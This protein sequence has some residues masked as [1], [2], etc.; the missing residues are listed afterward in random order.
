MI[1]VFPLW[2]CENFFWMQM[3]EQKKGRAAAEKNKQGKNDEGKKKSRS[4]FFFIL[5]CDDSTLDSVCTFT[6]LL[7][8]LIPWSISSNHFFSRV[9][10]D[11]KSGK[12]YANFLNWRQK[13]NILFMPYPTFLSTLA[14]DPGPL[15][16]ALLFYL[17]RLEK[18]EKCDK[19]RWCESIKLAVRRDTN[20]E[21][22][23]FFLPIFS[24]HP[25]QPPPSIAWSD[26]SACIDM[27]KMVSSYLN[28]N[29]KFEKLKQQQKMVGE[30][31]NVKKWRFFHFLSVF[32]PRISSPPATRQLKSHG[33]SNTRRKKKSSE[34]WKTM[35]RNIEWKVPC[36]D[37][38]TC[39]LWLFRSF[40]SH[41]SMAIF[42]QIFSSS[43][44]F[45]ISTHLPGV[46]AFKI[47]CSLSQP[48]HSSLS[49]AS[50]SIF[51][52]TPLLSQFFFI[53]WWEDV[54]C[55][56]RMWIL[57]YVYIAW[58]S[59]RGNLATTQAS[60]FHMN[61]YEYWIYYD[62]KPLLFDM[63]FHNIFRAKF[64]SEMQY[65]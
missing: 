45:H 60:L 29:G 59:D 63:I 21:F 55:A 11:R 23:F 9:L 40:R 5:F 18:M 13:L 8:T 30:W 41:S 27:Y 1:F 65:V 36:F 4:R 2:I 32:L 17:F 26:V 19:T 50:H 44:T 38:N 46:K 22:N 42:M 16:L 14:P 10:V 7:P 62:F 25:S 43:F 47:L 53:L 37:A 12:K 24:I 49:A 20:S 15:S 58:K 28:S 34:M 64:H 56:A 57:K 51:F 33:N 48:L 61:L 52:P 54:V 6:M 3:K 35:T 31:L 39:I